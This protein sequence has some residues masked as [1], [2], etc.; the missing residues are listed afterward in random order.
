VI[1]HWVKYVEGEINKKDELADFSI[2]GFEIDSIDL[3]NKLI[4]LHNK[5]VNLVIGFYIDY[6]KYDFYIHS[7]YN[8]RRS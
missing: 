3:K 1:Y 5:E 4:Y 6:N 7:C 2:D 8:L